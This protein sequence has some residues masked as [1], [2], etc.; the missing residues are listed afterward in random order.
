MKCNAVIFSTQKKCADIAEKSRCS[1]DDESESE[2]A[3]RQATH[4][5]GTTT[6]NSRGAVPKMLCSYAITPH[7]RRTCTGKRRE[8]TAALAA[9]PSSKIVNSVPVILELRVESKKGKGARKVCRGAHAKE[10]M[11]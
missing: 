8:S 5:F 7:C 3:L 4:S 6:S 1:V 10:R 11:S 9:M 2:R